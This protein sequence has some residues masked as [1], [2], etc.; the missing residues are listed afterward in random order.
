MHVGH[1]SKYPTAWGDCTEISWVEDRDLTYVIEPEPDQFTIG[2]THARVCPTE[3]TTYTVVGYKEDGT[4]WVRGTVTVEVD[5]TDAPRGSITASAEAVE[6][7]ECVTLEWASQNI[8]PLR[9]TRFGSVQESGSWTVCPVE[10]VTFVL[11]GSAVPYR[12]RSIQEEWVLDE[13]TVRVSP[14][15]VTLPPSC[16]DVVLESSV[17]VEGW[18]ERPHGFYEAGLVLRA[19]RDEGAVLEL[20][21]DVYQWGVYQLMG[22]LA[23]AAASD[24][25]HALRLVWMRY[26]SEAVGPPHVKVR[27]CP[28]GHGR[29]TII[30]TASGCRVVPGVVE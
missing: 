9:I 21:V 19:P 15:P 22:W 28:T 30:C 5:D 27:M 25:R 4:P 26:Q 8:S 12:I 11:E 2:A 18:S 16:A 17:M 14:R 10:T 23:Q 20:D 7:G 13:V 1:A 6:W 3:T 29:Q 24:S